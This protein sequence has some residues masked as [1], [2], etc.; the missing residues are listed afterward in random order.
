[1][2]RKVFFCKH[3]SL[4]SF[5]TSFCNEPK[6]I[7]VLE[8]QELFFEANHEDE[9]DLIDLLDLSNKNLGIP[10]LNSWQQV[11][12]LYPLSPIN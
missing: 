1:M 6:L 4:T 3:H 12:P 11:L 8:S 5:T 7:K 9:N 2:N 10:N